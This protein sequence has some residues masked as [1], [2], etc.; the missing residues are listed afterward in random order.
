MQLISIALWIITAIIVITLSLRNFRESLSGVAFW[1]RPSPWLLIRLPVFLVACWCI[2]GGILLVWDLN[3]IMWFSRDGNTLGFRWWLLILTPI[4]LSLAGLGFAIP[5]AG[6]LF[7]I[8]YLQK[9]VRLSPA[10]R[11]LLSTAVAVAIPLL[12][13]FVTAALPDNL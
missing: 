2:Y 1:L 13:W 5:Y 11:L 8:P 10:V 9:S 4:V 12:I 6:Y 3:L 7:F